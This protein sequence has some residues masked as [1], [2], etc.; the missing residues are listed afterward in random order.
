MPQNVSVPKF[1]PTEKN[2]RGIKRLHQRR[3]PLPQLTPDRIQHL[4]HPSIPIPGHLI[5]QVQRIDLRVRS[6]QLHICLTQLTQHR[7]KTNLRHPAPLLA[8]TTSN[9]ILCKMSMP[10]LPGI[11]GHATNRKSAHT[12]TPH[13]NDSP[14][15]PK[16]RESQCNPSPARDHIPAPAPPILQQLTASYRDTQPDP[17]PYHDDLYRFTLKKSM[18]VATDAANTEQ[19]APASVM[20]E[21]SLHASFPSPHT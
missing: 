4:Q 8:A 3:R 19:S 2:L 20:S 15:L 21:S 10:H 6:R 13:R 16:P 14:A 12:P 7:R 11:A 1:L 5:H 18:A 9:A 17:S